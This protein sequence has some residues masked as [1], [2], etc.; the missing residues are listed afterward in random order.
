[1]PTPRIPNEVHRIRGTF[2]EDR[3][4]PPKPKPP[5]VTVEGPDVIWVVEA[6]EHPYGCPNCGS[7]LVLVLYATRQWREE[8]PECASG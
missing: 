8:C 5:V 4:G 1:M 6:G 7:P 3:H 2:R